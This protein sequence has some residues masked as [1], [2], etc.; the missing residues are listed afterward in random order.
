MLQN[1]SVVMMAGASML[2]AVTAGPTMVPTSLA[3]M[4]RVGASM[5]AERAL[6]AALAA[7]AIA[8]GPPLAVAFAPAG[9]TSPTLRYCLVGAC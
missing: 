4:M 1:P 2:A 8:A 7:S 9:S 6:A 5:L 3:V